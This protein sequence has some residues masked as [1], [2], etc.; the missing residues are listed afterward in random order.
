MTNFDLL[1]WIFLVMSDYIFNFPL[2]LY[3][4][5]VVS[6]SFFTVC[7]YNVYFVKIIRRKRFYKKRHIWQ[8]LNCFDM[9]H[10]FYKVFFLFY[11]IGFITSRYTDSELLLQ[12]ILLLSS[13]ASVLLYR[14]SFCPSLRSILN[15]SVLLRCRYSYRYELPLWSC[16]LESRLR[17]LRHSTYMDL[18]STCCWSCILTSHDSYSS[19]SWCY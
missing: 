16:N 13:S 14:C 12:H 11:L 10:L 1:I 3:F 19:C 9:S 2:K 4:I 18:Y 7:I 6:L 5:C 17:S 15:G 8:L